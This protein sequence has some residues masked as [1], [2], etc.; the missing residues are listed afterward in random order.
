MT[1]PSL[2]VLVGIFGDPVA[3]SRSPAMHNAAFRALKLNYVYLPFAIKP[4]RLADAVN[5]IR[6][7]GMAGVNLT[8]PHKERVLPYLDGLSAEARRIGAVNTVVN[9]GGR[10]IGHNTDGQGFLLALRAA[11]GVSMRGERVCVLGAGGAARAVA[12]ALVCAGVKRLIIANRNVDRAERLARA[13]RGRGARSSA[14]V[15]VIALSDAALQ[16]VAADCDYLVNATAVGLHRRDPRLASPAVVGCFSSVCDLI[17]QP[18]V[19]PLLRDAKAAGCRTMNGLD[20]LVYQGALSF[21]LWTGRKAPIA[22]MMRAAQ[23]NTA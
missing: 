3:H 21:R 13:I 23:A 16:R 11:W 8:I 4:S 2:P 18:A 1:R 20:M 17:Y 22:V 6:A 12:A 10:L 7:L 5:A 14:C 9:R 19:T 15:Q